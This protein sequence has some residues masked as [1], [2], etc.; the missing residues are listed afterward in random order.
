MLKKVI[1]V[2]CD[3]WGI[4]IKDEVGGGCYEQKMCTKF[5]LKK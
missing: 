5:C 3:T 1:G 2:S 4:K